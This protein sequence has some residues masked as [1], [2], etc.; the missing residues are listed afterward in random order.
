MIHGGT[1]KEKSKLALKAFVSGFTLNAI[2][3]VTAIFS[4][5][6]IAITD[7]INGMVEALSMLF[8]WIALKGVQKVNRE[9]YNYGRGKLENFASIVIAFA[10]FISFILIFK[11][12]VGRII[13]PEEIHIKAAII[14]VII[15]L[16]SAGINFILW[17]KAHH[18]H[19]ES[20]SSSI[21]SQ[22]HLFKEKIIMSF[23]IISSLTISIVLEEHG[24]KWGAFIDPIISICLA[25]FILFSAYNIIRKSIYELLDGTLEESL[26]IVIM[27]ELTRNF[28]EYKDIH[29]IR[30]H[31]AGEFVYIELFLEFEE[32][33]KMREV[34]AK[35]DKIKSDIES[36]MKGSQ[37]LVIST[38]K[39]Y[40]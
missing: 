2:G 19:K 37:V 32:E 13:H 39:P 8:A 34:Q 11:D 26:Q 15:S 3:F 4:H 9:N 17:K 38:N 27:R 20:P 5:S 31:R 30:S 1:V 10:L 6:L 14:Y 25:F 18:I 28:N 24:Y 7:T 22:E 29:G 33:M 21:N 40:N 12:A 35:M 23:V 36:R 16:C